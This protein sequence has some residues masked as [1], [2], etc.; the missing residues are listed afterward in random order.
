MY[1]ACKLACAL[2]GALRAEQLGLGMAWARLF[3]LYGPYEDGRRLVPSIIN[4]VLDGRE[5]AASEGTQ[6]R[7][8][9]HV[10]DVARALCA[11]AESQE[12]GTFNVCS[13]SPATIAD[14]MKAAAGAA[15]DVSLLRLGARPPRGWEPPSIVGDSARLR[16]ATGWAPSRTLADGMRET[17]AWWKQ[18]RAAVPSP[19]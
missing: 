9:L 7:D 18:F 1:A 16:A 4:A 15:G 19:G 8:Y 3:F 13:G 17:V 5:F 10:Q 14:L 2:I 12:R 11:L 6:V